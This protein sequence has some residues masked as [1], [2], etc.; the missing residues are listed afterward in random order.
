MTMARRFD[1]DPELVLAAQAGDQAAFTTLF[2]RWFDPCVDVARRIVRDEET[3]AEVAQETFLVAWRQLD[4]LRDPSAFGGWVL[5]TTRNK[6]LNRLERERRSVAVDQDDDPVLSGLEAVDDVAGDVASAEQQQLVWAAS[7]ALGEREASVLD[8]HLRHG[9]D[10]AEIATALDITTNNAHQVLFRMKGKL[11]GA[12]RAWVLFK[13][14]DPSCP[15]LARALRAAGATSFSAA[16]VKVIDRHVADCEDCTRRQAAILA[17]E[18]MFAAVP[19]LPVAGLLRE[20]VASGLRQSGVPL[21]PDAG[22]GPP[23]GPDDPTLADGG[24]VSDGPAEAAPAGGPVAAS[25]PSRGNRRLLVAAAGAVV[26][27][28]IVVGVVVA[29]RGG[30]DVD[31]TLAE[32]PTTTASTEV[33]SGT[34][35]P[36]VTVPDLVPPSVVPDPTTTT[37]RPPTTTVAPPV[38]PPA[39]PPPPAAPTVLTF[40]ATP[41]SAPGAPCPPGQWSFTLSWSTTA[42]T[43]VVMVPNAGSGSVT[44]GPAGT[45]QGCALSPGATWTLTAT[46]PGG[47]AT[48]T[49]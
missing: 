4:T 21:G 44:G 29:A 23:A 28:A 36:P 18:A 15:D 35:L 7:A 8:L 33:R 42:T 49:D 47:T 41:A 27:L 22:A 16:T 3:A 37:T 32:E 20:R 14:G 34:S 30:S 9:L 43:T 24:E 13:G 31:A 5:R 40:T 10:A 25:G 12:I 48:A 19:L 6:A 1:D 38:V 39:P 17:P 11:A 26:L 45:G 2:R 46:G